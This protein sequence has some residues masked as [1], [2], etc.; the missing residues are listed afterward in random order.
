MDKVTSLFNI[1]ESATKDNNFSRAIESYKE[2][3]NLS[4]ADI[5]TQ[6]I[7]NWGIGEIYLNN[8]E[9]KKAELYLKRAVDLNPN[10]ANYHYLLGCTYTY[11][12][13]IEKSIYHLKKAVELNDSEEIYWNQL[14]WVLG[15]HKDINE[16]INCLKKSLKINPN[17]TKS[18]QDICV[19]YA[20]NGK[21]G[22]ADICIDEAI[23]KDP[24][25]DELVEIKRV[26]DHFK[27]EFDRLSKEQKEKNCKQT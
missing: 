18:L 15:F 24:R 7:A 10:D 21:F 27:K 13:E 12:K 11:K 4:Q 5:R 14:G 22:E 20:K 9:Y 17:F 19:L 8:K 1:A 2:I 25:N 16:G 26:V 23:K 3:L 6:H